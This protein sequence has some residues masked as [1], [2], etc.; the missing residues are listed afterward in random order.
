MGKV[1]HVLVHTFYYT[2]NSLDTMVKSLYEADMTHIELYGSA[3]HLC[4]MYRYSLQERGEMLADW[5]KL[6]RTYGIDVSC[7]FI[8]TMD[9]PVNIA[10]ENAEV[11]EF[12]VDMTKHFIDDAE[13]FG[14][15]GILLDS[16]FG[17]YDRD[18]E[19]AWGRSAESLS[20][21]G[22]YAQEHQVDIYLRPVGTCSNIVSDLRD[23]QKMLDK[24][25]CPQIKACAD[26]NI[27]AANGESLEDYISAFGKDLGYVRIGNFSSE[28]ELCDGK[29]T[30]RLKDAIRKLEAADYYGNIGIEIGWERLDAPDPATKQLAEVLGNL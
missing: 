29:G 20:L 1:E 8:P 12:S 21:I 4:E 15:K 23:L 28:G 6:I 9:C 3:P 25:K 30:D 11:M 13:Y 2:H 14:T 10:D 7:I 18:R 22:N 27:A 26:M 24:L 17:L 5:R 16:G 19:A